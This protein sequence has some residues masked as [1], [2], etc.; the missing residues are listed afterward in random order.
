MQGEGCALEEMR[1]N[2]RQVVLLLFVLSSEV[3]EKHLI[4]QTD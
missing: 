1:S 2:I 3:C 4:P